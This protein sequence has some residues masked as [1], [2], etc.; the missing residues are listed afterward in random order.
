MILYAHPSQLSNRLIKQ[1]NHTSKVCMLMHIAIDM[2][3][4]PPFVSYP[5]YKFHI[6]MYGYLQLICYHTVSV[7]CTYE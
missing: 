3:N 2:E 7:K 1:L 4:F 5:A 6:S